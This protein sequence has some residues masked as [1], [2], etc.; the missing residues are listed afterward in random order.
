MA[1]VAVDAQSDPERYCAYV[2]EDVAS[3]ARDIVDVVGPAGGD[4][5]SAAWL[6]VDEESNVTAWLLAETDPEM[7][8]VWWWGP[9]IAHPDRCPT[10]QRDSTFDALLAVAMDTLDG[11]AEHE[12][13]GDERSGLLASA[14]RRHGFVA[15]AASALLRTAPFASAEWEGDDD[16]VALADPHRDAVRRLHD[17]LF[18]GTHTTG[19]G[20]VAPGVDETRLVIEH[21]QP[22]NESPD[23]RVAGYIAT[24]P[25]S[26]G[27]L[28]IDFV[29]VAP[30]VRGRGLGRRLVSEAMRRGAQAGAT[31]AHLTVRAENAAARRMYASLGFVEERVV[32]PYRRGF[33]VVGDL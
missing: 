30:D 1:D 12:L 20:L 14:A 9:M 5:T 13:A 24:E 15:G 11:Y 31:H 32:V 7:G 3:I 8:R 22:S 27:S 2:S 18:S 29:G 26:D 23:R 17:E 16:V 21:E 6:E 10:S 33:A 25:H 19:A 28:Y 4:W